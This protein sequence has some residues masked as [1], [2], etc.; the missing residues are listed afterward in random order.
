MIAPQS[1]TGA[2]LCPEAGRV[3]AG[4]AGRVAVGCAGRVAVGCAGRVAVGCAGLECSSFSRIITNL[5]KYTECCHHGAQP[6]WTIM[7]HCLP[8]SRH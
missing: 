2:A 8:C 1:I 6:A 5:L 7:Q 3:A 4:C